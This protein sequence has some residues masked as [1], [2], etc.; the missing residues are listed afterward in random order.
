MNEQQAQECAEL[1]CNAYPNTA[2]KVAV[3]N[4]YAKQLAPYTYKF[5]AAT[6]LELPGKH[7]GQFCPSI[8]EIQTALVRRYVT[9]FWA[10]VRALAV[11]VYATRYLPG[12][13]HH[14]QA[15]VTW[16]VEKVRGLL[17]PDR[18]A[19]LRCLRERETPRAL[20]LRIHRPLGPRDG[21]PIPPPERKSRDSRLCAAVRF[22]DWKGLLGAVAG[23]E[24]SQ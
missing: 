6:L 4:A 10:E 17:D 15:W 19:V 14:E 3:I 1:I 22:G 20:L 23:G 9:L 18:D 21:G 8:Q 13:A 2:G 16:Y 24:A 5:T 11:R 12:N 7:E